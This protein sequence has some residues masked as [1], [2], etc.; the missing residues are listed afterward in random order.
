MT[1]TRC[2]AMT[3]KISLRPLAIF[4][5][6]LLGS[7]LILSVPNAST[8]HEAKLNAKELA[9]LKEALADLDKGEVDPALKKAARIKD[10]AAKKLVNWIWL[11]S[12]K[13]R[14]DFDAASS[15]LKAN[16][17]WPWPFTLHAR[18][19]TALA[20]DE[21]SQKALTWFNSHPPRSFTGKTK[22]IRFLLKAKKTEE[23]KKKLV[24]IWRTE[25]LD[26]KEQ[27]AILKEFGDY[28]SAADH[29]A[30]VDY[31]LWHE[32]RK[33]AEPLLKLV[34]KEYAPVAAA[35]IT[36]IRKRKDFTKKYEAVPKEKRTDRGLVYD[37][38]RW[39]RRSGNLKGAIALMARAKSP[40]K[41]FAPI[42]WEER[43][44]LARMALRNG[45]F[46]D[47]YLMV[48]DS[49]LTEGKTFAEVEFMA[50]WIALRFLGDANRA[51][52]HF[53]TLHDGVV[54]PVSRARA[55]YWLGR[56]RAAQG[57]KD[58]AR[59]WYQAAATLPTTYYGQLAAA[60]LGK[61]AKVAKF[62]S[63]DQTHKDAKLP[64]DMD[65]IYRAAAYLGQLG[66]KGRV[67]QF[68]GA[69]LGQE[70]AMPMRIHA[71]SLAK[72]LGMTDMALR[73]GKIVQ[74]RGYGDFATT[75]PVIDDLPVSSPEMSLVHAIIRQ[76]SLFDVDAR[77]YVGA[78]GLMQL[79]P[80]TAKAMAKSLNL[81]YDLAK[82]TSDPA[83]NI[84]L[85]AGYLDHVLEKFSG[86]YILAITSYNAGPHR[87]DQWL[88]VNGDPRNG[89]DAI[90][91]IES[92]PFD[93]TRN[94]VQR[95]V[96]NLQIY[97]QI[98]GQDKFDIGRELY[99]SER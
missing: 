42:W 22:E 51:H 23:A 50:G 4:F 91:W 35:R 57:E 66:D 25:K 82:L 24:K 93:E 17:Q 95:V 13:P 48:R 32:R 3:G 59:K 34:S 85:G 97:R 12:G 78:R 67:Y 43:T 6:L 86:S 79:M 7:A 54:Y 31:L 68:L 16:D 29:D 44:W 72:Q 84:K 55:A 88:E 61:R 37:R 94:Y 52:N 14:P 58:Q 87:V 38:V 64:A 19:E 18:A 40:D 76:E 90:D 46:E 74:A 45:M 77:S 36:V 27:A 69:L 10:P 41:A 26:E 2:Q 71:I 11:T 96:E 81:K 73:W 56:A 1:D 53:L 28:L 80:G 70:K 8:A 9:L 75:Y 21:S 65:E 62:D 63:L 99:L 39:T 92:I 83:Y 47:A 30:R 15:F 49:G 33:S 60:E 20:D 98:L 5:A 89:T